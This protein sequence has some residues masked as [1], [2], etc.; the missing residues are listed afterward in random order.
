[1]KRS[2]HEEQPARASRLKECL[3]RLHNDVATESTQ[4]PE[5]LGA[6]RSQHTCGANVIPGS[7]LNPDPVCSISLKLSL[8]ASGA[9]PVNHLVFV[10]Q[11]IICTMSLLSAL[12][13]GTTVPQLYLPYSDANRN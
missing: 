4:P 5:T 7:V 6:K 10:A 1:M 3:K 13:T 9:V 11:N 12:K 2:K 8:K